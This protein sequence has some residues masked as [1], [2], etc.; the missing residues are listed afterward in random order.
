MR[1]KYTVSI[2]VGLLMVIAYPLNGQ[3]DIPQRADIA[4]EYKWNLEDIYP[5]IAEWEADYLL[6]ESQLEKFSNF[7]GKLKKSGKTI[8]A[9]FELDEEVSQILED[10]YVY[11]GLNK[12]SD[13]RVSEFQA[14]N[15][16][17]AALNIK[18]GEA[19]AF[20]EPEL[21]EIPEN[22][23]NRYVKST[24]GLKIYE[25]YHAISLM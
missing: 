19:V 16:R 11:A 25:H 10:L 14:L 20:I 24:T 12:D 1:A 8:L 3:S 22:R 18:Y 13:T 9:C 6:V 15:D 2:A 4:D 7:K 21:Q 5:S 17:A 23:L